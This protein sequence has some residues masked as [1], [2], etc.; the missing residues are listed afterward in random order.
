MT[1]AAVA[2]LL[3]M[4]WILLLLLFLMGAQSALFGPVK[5]S[6]IPQHLSSDELVAGNGLVETGTFIAILLGTIAAGV[7]SQ[8]PAG[9]TWFALLFFVLALLG[10]GAS[11][12]IP[13]AP[14]T[15]PETHRQTLK[16]KELACRQQNVIG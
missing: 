13:V 3:D 1:L 8:W 5:Y 12:K 10:Y 4:A 15:A 7:I 2:L 16:N 14:A 6:I 11:R 9:N